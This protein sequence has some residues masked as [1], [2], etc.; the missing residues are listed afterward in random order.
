[1]SV[2]LFDV[3]LM[4]ISISIFL[5]NVIQRPDGKFLKWL[6]GLATLAIVITCIVDIWQKT[7]P[8]SPCDI[9][10]VTMVVIIIFVINLLTFLPSRS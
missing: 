1:M 3:S 2:I 4:L 6:S 10:T 9:D 7:T 5:L 8:D